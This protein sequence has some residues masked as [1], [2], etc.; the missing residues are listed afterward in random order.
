MRSLRHVAAAFS[1]AIALGTPWVAS[2]APK[3]DL[4]VTLVAPSAPG[5]GDAAHYVVQV[6]NLS[7]RLANNVVLTVTL[8]MTNTTPVRY[9]MGQLSNVDTRCTLQQTNLVCALNTVAGATT[10][11]PAIGFDL[12]LPHTT[13]PVKVRASVSSSTLDSNLGNNSDEETIALTYESNPVVPLQAVNVD[14]C[15][16]RNLTS[17][18]ECVLTPSS[19]DQSAFDLL[20]DQTVLYMGTPVGYWQQPSPDRLDM[21]FGTPGNFSALFVGRGVDG[22]CFE[23][24]TT[25]PNDPVYVSPWRVCL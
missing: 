18:Y 9:V 4:S 1:S 12:A 14:R 5:V 13:N 8:P 16:G 19:I 24:V 17:F 2:A 10:V 11:S 20:A 22:G 21:Q 15:T 23:G 7:P 3:T 6:A 25:F